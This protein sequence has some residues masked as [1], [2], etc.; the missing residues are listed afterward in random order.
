[1]PTVFGD[2]GDGLT[3]LF[4]PLR[5]EQGAEDFRVSS[6]MTLAEAIAPDDAIITADLETHTC[7]SVVEVFNHLLTP[8]TSA[9]QATKRLKSKTSDTSAFADERS[10]C[11]AVDMARKG[12][13]LKRGA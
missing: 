12:V 1:M 10:E 13:Y 7:T 8:S 9:V 5:D 2:F 6:L 11:R 3:G 4:K